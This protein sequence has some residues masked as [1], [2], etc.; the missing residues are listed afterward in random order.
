MF[1]SLTSGFLAMTSGLVGAGKMLRPS[2]MLWNGRGVVVSLGGV[3]INDVGATTWQVIV[4]GGW[5][6]TRGAQFG[7]F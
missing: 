1:D 7:G 4:G 3:K 2:G 5:T 6:W